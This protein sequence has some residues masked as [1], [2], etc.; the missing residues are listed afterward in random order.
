MEDAR[1]AGIDVP[2]I[3][4]VIP[5]V[6]YDQVKRTC[7]LCD[8]SIPANLEASLEALGGDERAEY[9]FGIS[10]G[11]GRSAPGCWPPARRASTST[12]S[13]AGPRRGRSWGRCGPSGRG[14]AA[15]ARPAAAAVGPLT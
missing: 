4:G 10:Y 15:P 7:A 1:A 2:I 13:T 11:V 14:S 8:A 12:R 5:I 9:E 6:S 3:P